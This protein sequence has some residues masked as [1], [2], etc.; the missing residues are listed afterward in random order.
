[1]IKPRTDWTPILLNL[2]FYV[3]LVAGYF[4]CLY[5]EDNE[6]LQSILKMFP[7]ISLGAFSKDTFLSFGLLISSAGDF[8]LEYN[9][10]P[11]N[12]ELGIVW[13]FIAHV[14]YISSFLQN[15]VQ[16]SLILLTL[17]LTQAGFLLFYTFDFGEFFYP[18]LI[19]GLIL[20]VMLYLSLSQLFQPSAKSYCIAL[21]GTLFYISDC[22]IGVRNFTSLEVTYIKELIMGLYYS[23]QA[24]IFISGQISTMVRLKRE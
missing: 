3:A 20:N 7:V 24:F 19:Y 5:N 12:F 11:H 13:F 15:G 14:F 18:V 9:Q 4:Y 17:I 21:G 16:F 8:T 2:L 10:I 1:M 6:L 23:G 22:L